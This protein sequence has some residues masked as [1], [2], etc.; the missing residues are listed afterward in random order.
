MG[1]IVTLRIYPSVMDAELAHQF[2]ADNGIETSIQ[3]DN[4]GGMHPS[5][6]FTVGV[7]LLIDEKD[8]AKAQDLL[9][10]VK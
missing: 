3:V 7:K 6:N 10:L 1:R 2:M 8:L 5:L 9:Q 4:I